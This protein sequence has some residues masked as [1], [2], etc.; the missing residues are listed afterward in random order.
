M[1]LTPRVSF[2]VP[3]YK[4]GHF[5][6]DCLG[7]ILSQTFTDLEVLIMDDCSPDDTPAIA[8]T[9]TD[10]RV[11]HI[12]NERNLGHLAN[13]NRGISLARGEFIWLINV[14]DYLRRPYVLERFV[15][16]LDA[17][18]RAAYVFCPAVK[19]RDE[20]EAETIMAHG[21]ADRV[22]PAADFL[23]SLMAA[24]MV[25]TPA[26]MVRRVSYERR[27]VFPLD[28]PHAGDWYQWCN[29]AF[30]G[31]VAYV[32]EPMVCYRIH[33]S[34]MTKTYY[35]RPEALMADLVSVRRRVR[36]LA[37]QAGLSRV[38]RAANTAIVAEYAFRI[39]EGVDSA[40]HVGMTFAQFERSLASL[41]NDEAEKR[42]LTARVCAVLGDA[43][44]AGGDVRGARAYYRQSL[45]IEPLDPATWLKLA[46][47][48]TGAAGRVARSALPALLAALR[49]R[50][51]AS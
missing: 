44:Y 22:F 33:D 41:S 13:Y 18:R 7:S 2:I 24:N 16:A 30:Y 23:E 27:G 6:K 36:D 42:T 17:N 26:V 5:L 11:R 8:R 1:T 40:L 35:G 29:H 3:C 46:L 19:V 12:R 10:P 38:V 15:A 9:F 48:A 43:R 47:A 32:A 14:D 37:A 45:A 49:L 21:G 50:P 39:M 20:A 28:L 25:P 51:Q 31:D 4:H 34:N